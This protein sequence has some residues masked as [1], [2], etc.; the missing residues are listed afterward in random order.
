[1]WLIFAERFGIPMIIGKPGND[2]SE[3]TRKALK[4]TIA[5]LGTEGRAILGGDAT[6]EVHEQALRAGGGDHLHAGITQ[7]ADREISKCI[8][9]GTL[10]SDTGGPGSFALGQVHAA[11]EHKLHLADARRIG[12]WL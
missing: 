7:L 6:I 8:T 1:D 4:E 5:A 9:G 2:D 3:K 10:T 12:R 11:K